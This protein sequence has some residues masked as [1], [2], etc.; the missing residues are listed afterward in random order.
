MGVLGIFFPAK[1]VVANSDVKQSS[2]DPDPASSQPV[3][4]TVPSEAEPAL[5]LSKPVPSVASAVPVEAK[6][7]ESTTRKP[8]RRLSFRPF[9]P[10]PKLH[11]PILSE[12]QEHEKKASAANAFSK[13]WA[14]PLSSNSDKRAKE[15]ALIVRTLIVGHTSNDFSA[16]TLTKAIAT[17][18]LSKVK[19]ELMQ[20]NSANKLI[21][22]LRDL[23]AME[24]AVG[25]GKESAHGPIHAV[26]LAYPDADEHEL[27]FA[28]LTPDD[29]VES[30][31][32][33]PNV[34]SASMEKLN[35]MLSEM[36]IVDLI[37]APDLGIGQPG[38]GSG[39]LAGALPTAETVISGIEQLTPQLM[40][41]GYATGRAVLPDHKG[42]HPPTDRISVITYWWGL[43]I[44]LPEP[45]IQYLTNA[46]SISGTLVNFLTALSLINNGVREI[47]PFVRYIS[48]FIDFEFKT[49]KSQD[50][51]KGVVCAAT[52]IMPAALVTKKFSVDFKILNS[53]PGSASLG[54]SSA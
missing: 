50:R 28:Q 7:E 13:R 42:V 35:G 32:F 2:P 22:Q 19:S 4:S 34:G 37:T 33:V 17:P 51:G 26:C 18:Q 24:S 10:S 20:P 29:H 39:L 36:H 44:V 40:A 1:N 45:T 11:K 47:L 23:P 5:E 12:S 53:S 48:Q 3:S 49:I 54:F 21:A 52:W 8:T 30:S 6:A 27:H 43:E 25:D 31:R 9:A 16:P 38:N 46:Q 15:S 14:K 41:L